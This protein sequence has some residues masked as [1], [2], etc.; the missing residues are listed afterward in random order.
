VDRRRP[1]DT[2][3]PR[4]DPSSDGGTHGRRLCARNRAPDHA[5][6]QTHP[7]SSI[8]EPTHPRLPEDGSLRAHH[9]PLSDRHRHRYP[10][11]RHVSPTRHHHLDHGSRRFP[12][13]GDLRKNLAP[14]RRRIRRET[15]Q[16]PRLCRLAHRRRRTPKG[17]PGPARPFLDP[18]HHRPLRPPHGRPRP[19]NRHP[20]R[21]QSRIRSHAR[22][23]QGSTGTLTATTHRLGI[24]FTYAPAPP[25]KDQ[26]RLLPYPKLRRIEALRSFINTYR[27]FGFCSS[28]TKP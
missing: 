25:T 20:N 19:P 10:P 16:N 13:M 28:G 24:E 4:T 15:M 21:C 8:P 26:R 5:V 22:H 18:G 9:R 6:G 3:H 11:R 1:P 27:W 7:Q 14:C 2:S 23:Q 12:T 17:Y